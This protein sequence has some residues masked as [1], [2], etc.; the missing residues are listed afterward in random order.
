MCR[1][2]PCSPPRCWSRRV[3]YGR[4]GPALEAGAMG[5]ADQRR[6]GNPSRSARSPCPPRAARASL[7]TEA[8]RRRQPR[9]HGWPC[10]RPARRDHA[11]GGGGRRRSR[12][13]A[14]T[15]RV[16][17]A[18]IR[19][20]P[21][22]T[23]STRWRPCSPARLGLSETNRVNGFRLGLKRCQ[24]MKRGRAATASR[25]RPNEAE[26]LS[27]LLRAARAAG[28][29]A[30][31]FVLTLADAGLR[32]GEARA[33]TWGQVQW[34]T[35][36]EDRSHLLLI[37]RSRPT[38]GAPKSGRARRVDLSAPRVRAARAVRATDAPGARRGG[39]L[40]SPRGRGVRQARVVRPRRGQL[41]RARVAPD[42]R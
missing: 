10:A 28:L 17:R 5:G 24:Q 23:T 39:I 7:S 42:L 41:P 26:P 8:R 11:R 37:D 9:E 21:D 18:R 19:S 13:R 22:V 1:N 29:E 25:I 3:V 2:P 34:G 33:L 6:A 14:P 4:T 30:Y 12:R 35:G 32:L 31:A 27:R 38:H 40:V 36:A 15:R 20:R 16:G